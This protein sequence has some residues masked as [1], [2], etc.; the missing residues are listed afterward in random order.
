[1]TQFHTLTEA[2]GALAAYIPQVKEMLGKD[3]TLERMV[4]LM[5]A[6]GNSQKQLKIIHIA[7]TSGKTS[8]A[9]YIASLLKA[10][11]QKTGL[12]ISPHLDSVTERVQID[13]QPLSEA[14]FCERLGEF[15]DLIESFT[16]K[17]T[18]FELLMAFAYWYFAKIKVDYAVIE[19]GLGGLH[20][21]S[22][23]AVSPDKICVITDIGHDHMHVLGHSLREIATQKAGIIHTGNQV[24]MFK[25]GV[26][27]NEVIQNYASKQQATLSMLSESE[28]RSG[29]EE[30]LNSL[31]PYQQRNWLLAQQ[32]YDYIRS[33]DSLP[34]PKPE[35]LADSMDVQIPGRM[36]VKRVHGKTIVMDGAHNEQKMQA[37][38]SS[39]QAMY[40]DTKAVVLLSLKEG[41]EYE[42]V[43][44]LLKPICSQLIVTT[45]PS[46]QDIPTPAIAPNVLA[47]A[48]GQA[49]FDKVAAESD[50]QL[51]YQQFISAADNTGVITGSFYLLA[52]IRRLM[53]EAV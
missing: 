6:I 28:K 43:L 26:E 48:A 5:N 39:F 19:T 2:E 13:L 22:N 53:L 42:A 30:H 24:F 41:K 44:P 20:D 16:P 50:Y 10:A 4:P 52:S 11:G 23:I 1:M 36:D 25:Q 32:A 12:T 31:P 18:Y 46:A 34:K 8:T 47:Q 9:Y 49:G 15:L 7:G 51:A 37:F 35:Q 38:V 29:A 3:I 40:P 45:F 21:A 14:E 17:P 27:V 33:R